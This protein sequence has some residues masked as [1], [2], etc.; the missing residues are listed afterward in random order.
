MS[1]ASMSTTMSGPDT[2]TIKAVRQD[3]I[4]LLRAT[5][6]MSLIEVRDKIRSKFA[7]Q[8]GPPLTDAFTIG[9][10]P[11][12]PDETS[13]LAQGRPRSQSTSAIRQGSQP[14]LRFLCS[15][16]DWQNA[17][18]CCTGKLTLHI[19]DRF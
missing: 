14:R 10:A 19:F 18:S 12:N 15:E 2:F 6:S 9:F 8:D 16:D 3:T 4:I 13:P 5:Y 7:S 11:I 1:I 17:I